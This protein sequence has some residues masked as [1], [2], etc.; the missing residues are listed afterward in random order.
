MA[1]AFGIG[2]T[3]L[4]VWMLAS[5]RIGLSKVGRCLCDTEEVREVHG[6]NDVLHSDTTTGANLPIIGRGD[7]PTNR[8]M[9]SGLT[10]QVWLS[11]FGEI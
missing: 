10:E 7:Y 2:S 6:L 8:Q 4:T 11:T 3:A 5:L 9:K 1:S